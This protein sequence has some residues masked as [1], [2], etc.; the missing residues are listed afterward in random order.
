MSK[1]T[2]SKVK[3]AKMLMK[4]HTTSHE[5]INRNPTIFETIYIQHN[6]VFKLFLLHREGRVGGVWFD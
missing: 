6:R 2:G 4:L 1:V 3:L 5:F